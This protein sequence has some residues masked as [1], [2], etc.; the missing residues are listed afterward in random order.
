VLN[1]KLTI[2]LLFFSFCFFSFAQNDEKETDLSP[3]KSKNKPSKKRK[4]QLTKALELSA[5]SPKDPRRVANPLAPARAAFYSAILPGLGQAYNKRYW[6][7][8]IVYAALGTGVY[9]YINNNNEYN[10]FREAY[11]RR[12]AGFNDDAFQGKIS[13]DGLINAQK[14]FR[15]GQEL[16][17]LVTV[18]LYAL[19]I[20]DANVDAHLLQF[21]IDDKLS[22]KPHYKINQLNQTGSIGLTMNLKID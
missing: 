3:S 5:D 21:S 20:I 6:K 17:L 16:A 1:K 19:N 7:I 10:R 4:D 14:T 13:D 22:F 9:F 18:G 15:R 11:K 2:L 12:I 8:P